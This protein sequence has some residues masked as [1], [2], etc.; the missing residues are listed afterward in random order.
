MHD[1]SKGPNLVIGP[2]VALMQW[3]NEIENTPSQVCLLYHGSNRSNSIQELSQY[4]VILT[5]YS[6]L[7]SVYRKQNY[8]FK[9]KTD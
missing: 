2:T 7:E 8:G 9:R 4:D 1:R 6:V 3:K 5:S